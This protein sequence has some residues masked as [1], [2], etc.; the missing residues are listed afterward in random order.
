MNLQCI[1][2]TSPQIHMKCVFKETVTQLNYCEEHSLIYILQSFFAINNCKI[3]QC[4]TL[5]LSNTEK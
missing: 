1:S 5:I 2:P 3:I 4:Q